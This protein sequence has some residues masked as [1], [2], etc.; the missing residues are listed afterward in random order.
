M[1]YFKSIISFISL[2]EDI[3]HNG[4]TRGAARVMSE[5]VSGYAQQVSEEE[6]A[7]ARQTVERARDAFAKAIQVAAWNNAFL[8]LRRVIADKIA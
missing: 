1:L 7:L 3:H 4:A 8:T 6:E 5:T 2:D